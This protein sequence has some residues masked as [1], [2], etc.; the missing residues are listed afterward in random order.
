MQSRF[1]SGRFFL[2]QR[3]LFE[4]RVEQGCQILF[5]TFLPA[6]VYTKLPQNIPN[7]NRIY[8][9]TSKF[10]KLPQ[11]LPTFSILFQNIP[12]LGFLEC[13]QIDHL[14]TLVPKQRK[15]FT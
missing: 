4:I 12:E 10:T 9:M 15:G 3:Q 13:M 5:G 11:K 2:K 8:P 7:Y 6:W 1:R 14:A